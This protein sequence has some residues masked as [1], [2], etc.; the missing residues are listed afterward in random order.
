MII[1]I[2]IDIQVYSSDLSM[3]N[4]LLTI[5]IERISVSYCNYFRDIDS[6]FELTGYKIKIIEV[7]VV[8]KNCDIK[9]NNAL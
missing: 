4:R 2:L 1:G 7:E 6:V 5:V 9:V 8:A 3:V